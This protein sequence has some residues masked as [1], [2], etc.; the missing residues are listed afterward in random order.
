MML[1][2]ALV[3]F[4]VQSEDS[5]KR[6]W[7]SRLLAVA[8][9]GP[10]D[11]VGDARLRG[12]RGALLAEWVGPPDPVCRAVPVVPGVLAAGIAS[13]GGWGRQPGV[14]LNRLVKEDRDERR[15][16]KGPGYAG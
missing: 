16:A 12:G 10:R 4:R 8:A 15:A 3:C 6:L 13:R 5:R 7:L 1:P 9:P 14:H 2:P 11:C